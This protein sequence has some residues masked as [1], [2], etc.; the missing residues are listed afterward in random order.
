M[1][2]PRA[3]EDRLPTDGKVY[4]EEGGAV[5]YELPVKVL[6]IRGLLM[7]RCF[8]DGEVKVSGRGSA[9]E[10]INRLKR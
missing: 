5:R 10:F 4:P 7:I 9:W 6:G 2:R 1:E 3:P 8:E